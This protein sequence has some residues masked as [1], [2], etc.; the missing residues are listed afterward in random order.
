MK[1]VKQ[2][3]IDILVG[4]TVDG[5]KLAEDVANI[6]EENQLIILGSSFQDD[7]TEAYKESYPKLLEN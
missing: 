1:R 7:I 4:D 5:C 3:S 2:I 6:L